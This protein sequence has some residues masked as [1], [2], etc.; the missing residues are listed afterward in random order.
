MMHHFV[1]SKTNTGNNAI[2]LPTQLNS[3]FYKKFS[4]FTLTLSRNMDILKKGSKGSDVLRWQQFLQTKKFFNGQPEGSYG[5]FT[6]K[7]TMAFQAANKLPQTGEVDAAT[8]KVASAQGFAVTPVAT[9]ISLTRDDIVNAAKKLNIAPATMQAVCFVE[10][11]GKGFFDNGKPKIRFEGH[12][13]WKEL[14]KRGLKPTDYTAKNPDIVFQ[15]WTRTYYK[16]GP[17]E[18]ERLERA[19][20]IHAEAANA[21]TSWGLFQIMGFNYKTS[22]FTS[23]ADYVAAVQKSEREQLTAFGNFITSLGY[24]QYLQSKNWLEFAKHYNGAHYLENDYETKLRN[25]YNDAVKNGYAG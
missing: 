13:F 19:K 25:A 14:E 9:S 22:G 6:A 12:I 15:N 17:E 4:M 10:A 21:S 23:V 18:Y 11:S 1:M 2:I 3:V 24:T 5:D 8:V 16:N 20:K 7:A